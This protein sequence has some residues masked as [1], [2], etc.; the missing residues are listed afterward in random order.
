MLNVFTLTVSFGLLVLAPYVVAIPSATR[1][2]PLGASIVQ[3]T[4]WRA[5]VWQKL[6]DAG[7]TNIDFVGSNSGPS[8]CTLHG[9]TITFDKDHEGHSGSKATEFAKSGNV[10]VWF[11]K[12]KPDLVLLH[13]G[14]NDATAGTS[15]DDLM[16]AYDTLL[17]QMRKE[18]PNIR[19]VLSKLIGINPDQY[20]QGAAGRIHAYNDAMSEW[21][22]KKTET[23]SPVTLVDVYSG[24]EYQTMTKDGKH[25]NEAG[26]QFMAERYFPAIQHALSP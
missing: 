26:D 17:D 23:R 4:C 3:I 13:I 16:R 24:F 10:S 18:N 5:Y 9:Q 21:V 11:Q 8:T 12:E 15:S 1:I 2:M 19:L 22:T 7:V 14:T 20:G 6:H 25:P